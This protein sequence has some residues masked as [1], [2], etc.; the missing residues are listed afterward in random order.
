MLYNCELDRVSMLTSRR[1]D[2]TG[3]HDFHSYWRAAAGNFTTLPQLFREAGYHT[4]SMGKVITLVTYV[5]DKFSKC[6]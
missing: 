5:V 2:T 6:Q 1:P 4:A 3:L